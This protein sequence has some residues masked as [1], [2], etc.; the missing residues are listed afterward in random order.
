MAFN[1][2]KYNPKTGD[3]NQSTVIS[4]TA[5]GP[6]TDPI[7]DIKIKFSTLGN[8][9]FMDLTEFK[10]DTVVEEF[11]DFPIGTVPPG[12]RPKVETL[13]FVKVFLESY[14]VAGNLTINPDGSMR[15]G[16]FLPQISPFTNT[17][18][19]G[20]DS[21]IGNCSVMYSLDTIFQ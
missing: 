21:G 14:N 16:V 10:A 4:A 9:V 1:Y 2:V 3:L 6:W 17:L 18:W 5:S 20:G 13:L 11:I 12:Y 7:T 8:H 19:T 15:A